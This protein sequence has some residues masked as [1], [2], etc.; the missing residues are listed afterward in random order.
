MGSHPDAEQVLAFVENLKDGEARGLLLHLLSC[1]SCARWALDVIRGPQ[2]GADWSN[3]LHFGLSSTFDRVWNRHFAE[4]ESERRESSARL[5]ELLAVP[6]AERQRLLQTDARYRTWALADE[7]LGSAPSLLVL[8]P[9]QGRDRVELGL[10]VAEALDPATYGERLL[11]DLQ[12]RGRSLLGEAHRRLGDLRAAE[13]A[14]RRS[15]AALERSI[16][17]AETA[18]FEHLLGLLRRDQGR[19]PEARSHLDK[20]AAV[21][22]EV[23]DRERSARPVASLGLTDLLADRI[24]R[25]ETRLRKAL[26]R[27]GPENRSLPRVLVLYHLA[28]SLLELERYPEA[29]KVCDEATPLLAEWP[30]LQRD[31]RVAWLRGLVAVGTGD[32]ER[33]I[34][35]LEGVC[36]GLR[37]QRPKGP[38]VLAAMDLAVL[39]LEQDRPQALEPIVREIEVCTEAPRLTGSAAKAVDFLQD[40]ADDRP[41]SREELRQARKEARPARVRALSLGDPI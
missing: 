26:D 17:P 22:L 9:P 19:L 12:A 38:F 24:E 6:P 3:V 37:W 4:A 30:E 32:S 10:A 41:R 2:G 29:K 27:F 1:P 21:Y 8:D 34:P 28:L 33:A 15:E 35:L 16:D 25:A 11:A 5:D 40:L 18:R 14:F 31:P 20:A 13:R 7:A 36:K 39:Y 23:G